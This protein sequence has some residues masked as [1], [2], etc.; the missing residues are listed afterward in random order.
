MDSRGPREPCIRFG[1]RYSRV[2][3]S[4]GGE[5]LPA[6]DMPGHVWEL[7]CSKR[8][9]R[10]QNQYGVDAD[11]GCTRWAAHWRYL[12]NTTELSVCGGNEPLCQI[13]LTTFSYCLLSILQRVSTLLSVN[14]SSHYVSVICM[15]WR[16]RRWVIASVEWARSGRVTVSVWQSRSES[17]WVSQLSYSLCR[18]DSSDS[19]TFP[20]FPAER[21]ESE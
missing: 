9:S 19:L 17:A 13:S 10:G 3:G 20:I 7:I 5:N 11:W 15:S 2:R 8:L 21:W 14:G 16:C 1:S 6:R 12:T 18:V 4:F